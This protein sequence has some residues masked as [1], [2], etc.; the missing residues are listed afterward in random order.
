MFKIFFHVFGW[1][2]GWHDWFASIGHDY[3]NHFY[4]LFFLEKIKIGVFKSLQ[5]LE[6]ISFLQFE[7][8]SLPSNGFF[9]FNFLHWLD[10]DQMGTV[11]WDG[12]TEQIIREVTWTAFCLDRWQTTVFTAITTVIANSATSNLLC[13]AY[14]GQP[15]FRG[16]ITL[17]YVVD[18]TAFSVTG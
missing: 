15:S 12:R 5:S 14:T 8:W 11:N 7:L 10:K 17:I 3:E 1:W 6:N 18:E 4:L 13:Y 16:Q 9:S 2:F